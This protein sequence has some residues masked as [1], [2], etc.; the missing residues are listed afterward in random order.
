MMESERAFEHGRDDIAPR[1]LFTLTRFGDDFEDAHAETFS[2]Y[3]E[4]WTEEE[5]DA[6]PISRLTARQ[7]DQTYNP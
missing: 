4:D 5:P 2:Y 7:I 1:F 3:P 6:I